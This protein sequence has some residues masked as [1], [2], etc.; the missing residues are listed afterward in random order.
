MLNLDTH[1]LLSALQGALTA[2]EKKV[3]SRE[4]WGIPAI[5]L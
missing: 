1:I 3:L 4:R 2:R 5:V